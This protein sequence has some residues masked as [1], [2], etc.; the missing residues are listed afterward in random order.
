MPK[1]YLM[2]G[3]APCR[4]VWW[5]SLLTSYP[6][7]LELVDVDLLEKKEHLSDE[8]VAMNPRHCVPTYEDGELVLTESRAIAN[9]LLSQSDRFQP[10]SLD[11]KSRMEEMVQYDLGTLYR[12]IGE[13]V[14]PMLFRGEE[15]SPEKL[16]MV[17]KSLEYLD[18][19]LR[20]LGGTLAGGTTFTLADFTTRMSLTMLEF[21]SVDLSQYTNLSKW[22]ERLRELNTEAWETVDQPFKEWIASRRPTQG[23]K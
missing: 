20:D 18:N 2:R 6:E 19:R 16:S 17:E 12:R 1:L 7:K 8:F 4:L 13:Y 10:I 15:E 14:Y 21:T 3:S 5:M 9:R 23:R 22:C 11:E